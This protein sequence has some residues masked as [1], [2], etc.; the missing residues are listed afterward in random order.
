MVKK[1]VLKNIIMAHAIRYLTGKWKDVPV[2]MQKEFM[3]AED[4]T[5][6]HH[7][8]G[9]DIR[10]RF[11]WKYSD[12]L[13]IHPDDLSMEIIMTFRGKI[14]DDFYTQHPELKK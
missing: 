1:Y 5:A 9:Q 2:E 14:H 8:L 3:E 13:D 7:T 4:L 12:K 10:N 6:Y 11:L